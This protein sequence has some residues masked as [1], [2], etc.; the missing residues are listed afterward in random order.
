MNGN[1][2]GISSSKYSF[3]FACMA[4][5]KSTGVL[6]VLTTGHHGLSNGANIYYMG[7]SS[8][9]GSVGY[10]FNS[11]NLDAS[12][13]IP[14]SGVTPTKNLMN[15][16]HYFE[17]SVTYLVEN[18]SVSMYGAASGKTSGVIKLTKF[19]NGSWVDFAL[20]TYSAVDGDSGAPVVFSRL[21]ETNPMIFLTYR[22]VLGLHSY[23]IN[24]PSSPY[25]LCRGFSRIDYISNTL[26]V[27]VNP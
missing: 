23:S 26:N 5:N 25:H 15:G 22:Y 14:S 18:A 4:K 24:N 2:G 19:T 27:N 6:G 3:T 16:D 7:G 21:V 17:A 12:F 10:S 11:G 20:C 8:A 1:F 9:I 13:I